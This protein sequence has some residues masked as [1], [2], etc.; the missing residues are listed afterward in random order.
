MGEL[1]AKIRFYPIDPT[2]TFVCIVVSPLQKD[3]INHISN[4]VKAFLP[5]ML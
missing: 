2:Q 5:S 1:T 3:L 4:F